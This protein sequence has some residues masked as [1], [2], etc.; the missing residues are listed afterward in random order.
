[1]I[2]QR[3]DPLGQKVGV[4]PFGQAPLK[5]RKARNAVAVR[6][7]LLLRQDPLEHFEDPDVL[8][9]DYNLPGNEPM[10]VKL[11]RHKVELLDQE[12][13]LRDRGD[14]G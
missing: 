2:E 4:R 12:G 13:S 6:A 7:V 3:V 8:Q 5:D 14:Q 1:M 10:G 11:P 9:L